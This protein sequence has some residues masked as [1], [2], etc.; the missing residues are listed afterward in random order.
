L[1]EL[2]VRLTRAGQFLPGCAVADAADLATTAQ[3]TASSTLILNQLPPSQEWQ[4]LDAACAMLLPLA[5]GACPVFSWEINAKNPTTL[6]FELRR[7]AKLGNFTPEITLASQSI[8]VSSGVSQV[9]LD[10]SLELAESGYYFVQL[11]AN[12]DVAVRL[13]DTRITGVLALS[14]AFNKAVATSSVQNPPD[15]IGIDRFE[16]WLPKRRPAGKNLALSIQPGLDQF[17]PQNVQSGHARP[18]NGVNAWVADP[19]DP[20][21][22]LRLDWPQAISFT[23]LILELDS[24]WD[25]PME[26]VLM[27]HPEEVVPFMIRD[28]DVIGA[29]DVVLLQKRNHH[30]A[31]FTHHFKTPVTTNSLR[32]RVLATHGAPAAVFRV[33]ILAAKE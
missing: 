11:H 12:E 25:H 7:S 20:C 30:G 33:R 24:D 14:T 9:S 28:F 5:A 1:D 15:D 2:Q 22:E 13:S 3:V 29:D 23:T 26:S 18:I 21:P 31:H 8:E 6:R 19:N 10:F 16:F 27:T 4:A 32:L 17:Q